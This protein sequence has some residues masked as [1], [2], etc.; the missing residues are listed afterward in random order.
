M[1]MGPGCNQH[2]NVQMFISLYIFHV[3]TFCIIQLPV[4]F[5]TYMVL[6]CGARYFNGR[7]P[8]DPRVCFFSSCCAT[9]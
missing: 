4:G 8:G 9:Q 6:E 2:N 1:A 7:Q 5:R 3:Y